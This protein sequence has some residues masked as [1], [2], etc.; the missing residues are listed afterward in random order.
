MTTMTTMTMIRVG[1]MITT[2]RSAGAGVGDA[3]T[4]TDGRL[5]IAWTH[6]EAV[7][8]ALLAFLGGGLEAVDEPHPEAVRA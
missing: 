4:T 6:P 1:D 3:T 5:T 8:P 2:T 7:N